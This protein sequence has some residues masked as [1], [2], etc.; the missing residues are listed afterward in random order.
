MRRRTLLSVAS[1]FLLTSFPAFLSAQT[2]EITGTVKQSGTNAP[3]SEATIG[4]LGSQIGVRTNERGE[5]RLKIP[6]GGATI[7][8][9]AIGFKRVTSAI[10]ASQSTADFVLE[11]DVLQLE[12]VTVTGQA[13]TVDKRNASTAIASVSAEE[14]MTAPAKSVEG[15]LAGKVVGAT[16]FENSGVPGGGMQIQIR[17]ATSILGQGDPLYVVDGIIVSNASV[18]G[19]LASISRASGTTSSSQDQVV[20]RL[21]DMNPNDIENIEVLKSAA[22]TAIYGSRATNGVVV[23]TTKKGKAGETRYNI[24]QRVGGQQAT[25]LLGSRQFTSYA[26]VQPFLGTSSHADSIAKANCT[27]TCPNYDWEG[28]FYNNSAPSYETVFSTSGGSQNTRFYGSLNDRQ[29]PGIEVNTGARRTTGR[30]NLDQTIGEKFT[31]GMGVDFTH[32]LTANGIGNNDNAGLSPIYT[33][34]YSPAL[35]DLRT[36]DPLTKNPVFMWMN[37][38]GSGTSNPFDVINS[39]TNQEDTWHQSGNVRIGYNLLTLPQNNVQIT[40]IGGV[41]RFQLEGTQYSPN[42]MQYEPADGFLGTSQVLTTDSRFINQSINAVWTYSPGW[43]FVNSLQ[44]SV[45]GTYETQKVNNY[46]V[47][48]RGLTPTRLAATTGVDVLAGNNIVEFRDQSKYFNTQ[49]IA[50]D[51]KLALTYGVRADR[52]TANGDRTQF[53]SFP[54]YSGSYRFVEPLSKF[55]SVL[56][57]VKLRASYGRSGN[58]PTY[59]VRDV[60][61]SGGGV[62]SGA[63]SLVAST[64]LGNPAIKPEVMNEAEYG[65]DAALFKG[66]VGL[67]MSHYERVIKD[68]LVTFPL[69]PSSGLVSQTINGG[70]MSTRGFEAGLNLV[71]ISRRDLEWTLRTTYQ[72]NVQNV[73]QLLV[74]SFAAPNSFGVSYGRNRI[75]VGTRPSY[76]WGNVP[77]SCVNTTNA[78]GQLVVGTGADGQACHRI[79]PGQSLTGATIRDSIIADANPVGQTSFLNTVRFKSVTLT[80]LLDWRV[81]GYTSDMTNNL[82]DEGG[83]SRDYDAPSPDPKQTL[84]QYRYGIWSAG[85]IATYIE[86]GTFLKLRELNVAFQVPQHFASMVRARDA[87]I[88]LQGRNLWVKTNYW[89]FDPEFNNF[90]NQNFNRFV[91][92]APYPSN[93]QFFLSVDLGY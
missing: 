24:T 46:F 32:N 28:Q 81:G 33:F 82:F 55:T 58:R 59:Q 16:I 73:D 13:T 91:D 15:N 75:A 54:K 88:S 92:L 93:R 85:N 72:R 86:N 69:P 23:I 62:I 90:G 49:L 56:D 53:Y 34:G 12:G 25:R 19:G 70:Q 60:T 21:A 5:Y 10:G 52:G 14:L 29:N 36:I 26:Q 71:P 7:L 3:I 50:L 65:V 57:E 80:A 9:R 79:Y 4:L 89:S 83:N 84:G 43:K 18:P 31:V 67:E 64:S 11:K 8:V 37:G 6:N 42:R 30:I 20:N 77:Y 38:G 61:I 63:G 45:G 44:T 76:I 2:R 40:Y 35:Y 87:R 1:L 78:A 17:G 39:I 47:R 74:P 27:T 22:A 66:R 68:L 48:E 51:E 41:D